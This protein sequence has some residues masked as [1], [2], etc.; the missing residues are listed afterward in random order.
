M[1]KR[2]TKKKVDPLKVSL[3][4]LAHADRESARAVRS[5]FK[6]LYMPVQEPAFKVCRFEY[7][8]KKYN[9]RVTSDHCQKILAVVRKNG[10]VAGEVAG[11]LSALSKQVA[12]DVDHLMNQ[13]GEPAASGKKAVAKA[14]VL[15]TITLGCCVYQGGSTPNLS[16]SQCSH[17]NPVKWDPGNPTCAPHEP[18]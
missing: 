9:A 8:N 10:D 18:R 12:E 5:L 2:Q 3:K 14:R 17:Y 7:E 6:A 15:G 16:Q 13:L 11:L 1:A 4:L